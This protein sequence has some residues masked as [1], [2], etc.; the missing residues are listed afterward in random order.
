MNK[1]TAL[2]AQ[3]MAQ[4][5]GLAANPTVSPDDWFALRTQGA[6][7]TAA[8]VGPNSMDLLFTMSVADQLE[9]LS[10]GYMGT[11][12]FATGNTSSMFSYLPSGYWQAEHTAAAAAMADDAFSGLR[13]KTRRI[14][15]LS[16]LLNAPHV[17]IG[18]DSFANVWA[19][20]SAGLS[21]ADLIDLLTY[22]KVTQASSNP[23]PDVIAHSRTIDTLGDVLNT[24]AASALSYE[25]RRAL[26]RLL[27]GNTAT[28]DVLLS[29]VMRSDDFIANLVA[30]DA[31][32]KTAF[33][34]WTAEGF[35]SAM[36]TCPVLYQTLKARP[37]ALA[38]LK[39]K[40]A[41]VTRLASST[42]A[43]IAGLPASANSKYILVSA[44]SDTTTGGVSMNISGNVYG[45]NAGDRD[46][47]MV[48]FRY[49]PAAIP[50]LTTTG[51]NPGESLVFGAYQNPFFVQ[52]NAATDTLTMCWLAC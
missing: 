36:A 32:A 47:A 41:V 20:L 23:A 52:S 8:F 33:W 31:V 48:S 50:A 9:L 21:N 2:R 22:K 6:A 45:T 3:L 12:Q 15:L 25:E 43:A 38:A 44:S 18:G 42:S 16:N 4:S 14:V 35:S 34:D 28:N 39:A 49:K 1:L 29:S 40:G 51:I 10:G 30:Y 46:V 17:L 24:L 37:A 26:L 5:C 13:G 19:A 11:T 27:S 7:P